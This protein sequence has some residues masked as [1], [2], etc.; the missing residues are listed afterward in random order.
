MTQ[1]RLFSCRKYSRLNVRYS[2]LRQAP[3][4]FSF[5]E[6]GEMVEE[7]E[8]GEGTGEEEGEDFDMEEKD[9]TS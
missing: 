6:G 4:R 8:D 2:R 3:V 1:F 9:I 7:D 5:N